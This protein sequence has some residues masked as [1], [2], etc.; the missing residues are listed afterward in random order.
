MTYFPIKILIT[1]TKKE[2]ICNTVKDI[3]KVAFKVL[4]TKV[5]RLT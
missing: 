5:K 2:V 4:E 3:P 1:K